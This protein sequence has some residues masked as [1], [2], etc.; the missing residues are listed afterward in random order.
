MSE[1]EAAMSAAPGLHWGHSRL[2]GGCYVGDCPSGEVS[3][4]SGELLRPG[5]VLII[6]ATNNSRTATFR[7]CAEH[8][9]ALCGTI[10]LALVRPRG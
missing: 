3:P 9:A 7:L 6:E 8:A 5:P 2:D 4:G 10:A 1:Q